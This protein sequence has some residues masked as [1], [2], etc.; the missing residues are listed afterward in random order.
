M[1][2]NSGT[3]FVA[4]L[5]DVVAAETR[6]SGVDG[7][8]GELTIA[9]FP[10][11]ELAGRASFEEVLYLLWNDELPDAERLEKFRGEL[12][13]R[14]GVSRATMEL[15]RSVA[16]ER[17]PVM[18]ALR[19]AASTVRTGADYEEALALAACLPTIIA[20]YWR[21][22]G[23]EEP[24]GPD[25]ELGHAANYLYMLTGERPGAEF[26]RALDTYLGAVSDHGMNASTFV[27]RVIVST[28]SDFV[29]AVVG[30]IGALKGPLHGGAPG[31]ALDVVFEIGEAGRAEAYL[32]EKLWRGERLMGFGHRIYRVRD[33]RADV[34]ASAAER[35]YTTDGDRELYDLA[36]DVER[37][38][39]RL[40]EGHKPGRNLQTN[41]E[42][43][44]A[45]LLHGLGLP[46]EL[47]T[48]TFAI[49]RVAGW[50]A[51]CFEQRELDRLI[52]PQ[53]EYVGSKNRRW[54]SLGGV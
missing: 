7:E 16:E 54:K 15:L 4:G 26:A 3:G 45:L 30:A 18:D 27:A 13:G 9:G 23:G 12:A 6:L 1:G 22:L 36:L 32:R 48:P 31:P 37:T 24:V 25:P 20:A 47:F 5:E 8:A 2:E 49:G 34:L 40:L 35:L 44:T 14:R 17:V 29:S 51:H 28:R 53:S 21:M 42:F 11:E 38:A 33:P 46:T 39:L 43:Y 19:M 41:V 52:R 10:V 50:T